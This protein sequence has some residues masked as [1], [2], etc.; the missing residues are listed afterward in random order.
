MHTLSLTQNENN[1]LLLAINSTFFI[2][3]GTSQSGS[4]TKTEAV[5]EDIPLQ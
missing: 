4:F 3:E 1:N 5:P 2:S